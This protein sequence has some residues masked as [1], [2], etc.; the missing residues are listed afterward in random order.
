VGQIELELRKLCLP[1]SLRGQ[2]LG[3]SPGFFVIRS[4]GI[5]RIGLP[6]N[7]VL[8]LLQQSHLEPANHYKKQGKR[9]R[10]PI[11]DVLQ[12]GGV[13]LGDRDLRERADRYSGFLLLFI[14]TSYGISMWTGGNGLYY[15]LDARKRWGWVLFGV[16]VLLVITATLSGGFRA[17]PWDWRE[18]W[19]ENQN[20]IQREQYHKRTDEFNPHSQPHTEIVPHKPLD[21]I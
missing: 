3:V 6:L 21:T 11:V 2:R 7:Q 1:F 12:N 16:A 14:I 20:S 9:P 19:R 13:I 8:G 10:S 5:Q 4:L 18:R 17:F 15:A